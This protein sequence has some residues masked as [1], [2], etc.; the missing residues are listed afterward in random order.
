MAGGGITV[1]GIGVAQGEAVSVDIIY[2][3]IGCLGGG[4]GGTFGATV[5][6]TALRGG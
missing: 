3:D 2:G 1:S 5:V 4:G 6:A